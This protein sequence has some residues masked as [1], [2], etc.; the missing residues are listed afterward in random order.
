MNI[1]FKLGMTANRLTDTVSSSSTAENR[2]AILQSEVDSYKS[3]LAILKKEM[4]EQERALKTQ[5]ATLEKKQHEVWKNS[6]KKDIRYCHALSF[7]LQS[8]VTVRQESRRSAEAQSEMQ[9]LRTRLTTVESKLVEK[10]FEITKLTEEND[11]LKE[12]VETISRQSIPKSEP[13]KS[14]HNESRF[15]V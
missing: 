1:S 5:N 14:D 12:T 10:E 15:L 9:T 6:L 13:S 2:I 11:N 7:C 4:E 3:Q 8:W